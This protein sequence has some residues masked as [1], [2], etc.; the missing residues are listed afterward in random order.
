MNFVGD[1]L[2][3]GFESKVSSVIKIKVDV[4]E[5]FLVGVRARLREN[6]VVLSVN[7]QRRWLMLA[8]IGL[9][10]WIERHIVLIVVEH[11]ELDLVVLRAGQVPQINL[12]V[13]RVDAILASPC[14]VSVLPFKAL[15]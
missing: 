9:K 8:E 15:G 1:F 5:V 4:L 11:C 12:P 14:P 7:D 6:V 13:V 2:A 10:T 3:M